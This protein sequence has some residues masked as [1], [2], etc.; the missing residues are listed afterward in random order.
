M[1]MPAFEIAYLPRLH[2]FIKQRSGRR[3][4][5]L[6]LIK[7]LDGNLILGNQDPALPGLSWVIYLLE[8]QTPISDAN[9]AESASIR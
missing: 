3:I 4:E 8:N 1:R 9:R 2:Y 5:Y 6:H 7:F